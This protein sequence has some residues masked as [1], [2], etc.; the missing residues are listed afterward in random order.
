MRFYSSREIASQMGLP[1]ARWKRWSREFLP[2][3][4]LGGLQSGYARQY[5]LRDAFTVFLGG[6]LVADLGFSV[7]EARGILK[8]SD[9]WLRR[10]LLP[11]ADRLLGLQA[12]VATVEEFPR[13]ELLVV[14]ARDL[15]GRRNDLVCRLRTVH[16][17]ACLDAAAGRYRQEFQDVDLAK[18]VV[19]EEEGLTLRI[20]RLSILL[21]YFVSRIR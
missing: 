17:H 9:S 11:V 16:S 12:G 10:T 5:S 19:P 18:R 8:Q 14:P 2:P 1:L 15:A 21:R 20:V 7:P 3:D 13:Y 4:P 6:H